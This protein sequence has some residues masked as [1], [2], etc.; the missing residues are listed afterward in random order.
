MKTEIQKSNCFQ[1][2]K[3]TITFE[4]QKELDAFGVLCN[5]CLITETMNRIGG[6]LPDYTVMEDLGANVD[7]VENFLKEMKDSWRFRKMAEQIKG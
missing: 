5:T 4:S 1:P 7:N 3:L 6:D 2:V